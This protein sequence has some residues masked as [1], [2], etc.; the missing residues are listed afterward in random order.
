MCVSPLTIKVDV[1]GG[2]TRT[3]TVPCGKCVECL[4]TRQNDYMVRI[5]EELMQA[6][7]GCFLTLT[8]APENVPYFERDCK[9]YLT[10]WKPDVHSWLKRF[11]TNYE[12]AT[13]NK[14]VRF[15]LC[16]EYGPKTHRPHYHCIFFGLD[17]NDL[18]S[19]IEDWR[20]RFGYVLAKDISPDTASFERSARYVSK[21][22]CKGILEDPFR[23]KE[24]L[25]K[26]V[27]KFLSRSWFD[28]CS[29]YEV[30]PLLFICSNL[31]TKADYYRLADSWWNKEFYYGISGRGIKTEVCLY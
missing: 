9:K 15:F 17:R 13:G 7:K 28:V 18:R 1:A 29:S 22:S 25:D 4:K 24:R 11:R 19:A 31:Y 23:S 5:Y 21:Y 12:R 20:E 26:T 2:A 8:Y 16:S 27:E 14:G 10:V 3:Y 6:G 30:V